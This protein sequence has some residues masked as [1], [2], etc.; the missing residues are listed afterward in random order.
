M[1][2][3]S[4]EQKTVPPFNYFRCSFP[5]TEVTLRVIFSFSK[6]S[7]STAH[8]NFV[9]YQAKTKAYFVC[10]WLN[11]LNLQIENSEI[12]FFPG[13]CH[14]QS[15]QSCAPGE[16]LVVLKYIFIDLIQ[17]KKDTRTNGF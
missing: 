10:I 1:L 17:N 9:T 8:S 6:T 16:L 13:V 15:S 12:Y 3:E 4:F 7:L 5:K 14:V 2:A 11:V